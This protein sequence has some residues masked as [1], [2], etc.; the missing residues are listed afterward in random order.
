MSYDSQIYQYGNAAALGNYIASKLIDFG[1]NDG[2]REATNYDNA[3]YMPSNSPLVLDGYENQ[4]FSSFNPNNWQPLTLELFIDQSGNI[5]DNNT[6]DFLSPEWGSVYPFALKSSQQNT[7]SKNNNNYKV[8]L[9]PGAPPYY[10]APLNSEG[11]NDYKSGFA[12]VSV[13]G[14]HLDS[15]DDVLWDISPGAIGNL[16][17]EALSN[18]NV[19]ANYNYLDGGF[20]V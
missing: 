2:S 9:D 15:N 12:M 8:Y 7:F 14:S 5:T 16:D 13:W 10:D 17:F 4:N 18:H 1:L 11:F 20:L 19:S 3:F 6:P